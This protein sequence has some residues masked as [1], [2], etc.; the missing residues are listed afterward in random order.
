MTGVRAFPVAA[1]LLAAVLLLPAPRASA[2]DGGAAALVE[3]EFREA[4]KV[5][6]PATVVCVPPG[7]RQ[8][9]GGGFD[10]SS[11]VI[12]TKSGYVLSDADAGADPNADAVSGRLQR[13]REGEHR[14]GARDRSRRRRVRR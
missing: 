2:A 1:A 13:Q 4:I 14:R 10:A 12:V 11:G 8:G 7:K 5:V 6:T 3:K 9:P